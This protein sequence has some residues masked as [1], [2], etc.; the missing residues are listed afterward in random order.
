MD[1]DSEDT[2]SN[3]VGTIIEDNMKKENGIKLFDWKH[4]WGTEVRFDFN[5]VEIK[6]KVANYFASQKVYV[7]EVVDAINSQINGI[8]TVPEANIKD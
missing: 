4:R 7:V 2:G 6:G 5:S 1:S 8:L 3:P